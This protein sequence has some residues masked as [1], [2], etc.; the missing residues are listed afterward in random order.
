MKPDI[1]KMTLREKIGQTLL[2]RQPDL[3][4]YCD[5]MYDELR[6]PGDAEKYM[7]ELQFGG[8]WACGNEEVDFKSLRYSGYW[9]FDTKKYTAWVEQITKG[10]KIPAILANDIVGS[11]CCTDLTRYP[12]TESLIVGA[13]DDEEYSYELGRCIGLEHKAAGMTWLWGPIGDL[14]IRIG[15]DINRAFA[16]TPELLIRHCGAFIKGMQDAGVAATI[17]HFPGA[18]ETDLRDSHICLDQMYMSMDDWKARQG[19]IFREIIDQGVYAVMGSAKLFPA[20]DD[21]TI[22]NRPVPNGLSYKALTEVLKGEMGFQGVII[23]DDVKMGGYMSCYEHNELYGRLLAAGN[24]MLLGVGIDAVDIV[25]DCV[26]RGIVTE[27]RINDACQRVLDMK[28]KVGLFDNPTPW[29]DVDLETVKADTAKVSRNIAEGGITLIKNTTNFVP[30]KE[31]PKNVTI[32]LITHDESIMNN[33]EAMKKAFEARGAHVSLRRRPTCFQ[34][35]AEVA[36]NSDLIVYAAYTAHFAP[37]GG[38]GF[39]G[40]EW[41]SIQNAFSAGR[42]KS[43]GISLGHPLI[44]PLYMNDA[45]TFIN[46]YSANEQVLE[47]VVAAIYGDIAFRGKSPID[48]V[49]PVTVSIT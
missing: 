46:T 34:E 1:T 8:L 48:M 16:A 6:D 30:L 20:M 47:A 7:T 2:V 23:S 45:D 12:Y 44:G 41:Y 19:R 9:K 38:M 37:M 24:D 43:L 33:M 11:Q 28:E 36:E 42:E 10:L 31:K 13:A 22:N 32:F 15:A 26:R 39:F 14:H 40:D 5:K 4:M 29:K 25:E 35:V 21:S 49:T 18:D 17:K 27:E 3:L